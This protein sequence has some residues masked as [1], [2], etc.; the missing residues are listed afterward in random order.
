MAADLYR[1]RMLPLPTL[2][3]GCTTDIQVVVDHTRWPFP[4]PPLDPTKALQGFSFGLTLPVPLQFVSSTY[5]GTHLQQQLAGDP[6]FSGVRAVPGS[7][8]VGV[9]CDDTLDK[10]LSE[11]T[12]QIVIKIRV[13][14][15]PGTP[16]QTLSLNFVAGLGSPPVPLT[17][18]MPQLAVVPAVQGRTLTVGS[19]TCLAPTLGGF[20]P[21]LVALP[22]QSAEG[23][24]AAAGE[25]PAADP[26]DEETWGDEE[27]P[28]DPS[29]LEFPEPTEDEL[30]VVEVED[31]ELLEVAVTAEA[32]P[33]LAAAEPEAGASA[34]L[35]PKTDGSAGGAVAL[36]AAGAAGAAPCDCSQR[37]DPVSR[38]IEVCRETDGGDPILDGENTFVIDVPDSEDVVIDVLTVLVDLSFPLTASDIMTISLTHPGGTTVDLVG[39]GTLAPQDVHAFF[40]DEGL[41]FSGSSAEAVCA[42]KLQS[43]GLLSDLAGLMTAGEWELGIDVTGVGTATGLLN[44]CCILANTPAYAPI[45]VGEDACDDP[46]AALVEGG[47]GNTFSI[48]TAD[49]VEIFDLK[50]SVEITHPDITDLAISIESPAGTTVTLRSAGAPMAT[51]I[52]LDAIWADSGLDQADVPST[53][54]CRILPAAG[55]LSDFDGEMS[56]PEGGSWEL[57]ITDVANGM[58]GT[59]L[60][61]CVLVNTPDITRTVDPALADPDDPYHP[62]YATIEEAV[63]DAEEGRVNHE[64]IR[65]TGGT[66]D[67]LVVVNADLL[68]RRTLWLYADS[69]PDPAAPAGSPA[70]TINGGAALDVRCMAITG[71]GGEECKITIGGLRALSPAGSDPDYDGWRGFLLVEGGATIFE[72]GAGILVGEELAGPPG[73]QSQVNLVGNVI[74]GNGADPLDAAI[75][76]G[77]VAVFRSRDVFIFQN[78]VTGNRARINGAGL[79]LEDSSTVLVSNWIDNNIFQ[80]DDPPVA[81]RQ[82]GG[83]DFRGG[84]AVMCAN[85]IRDN[86]ARQG[87]GVYAFLEQSTIGLTDEP[88]FHFERN[89]VYLNIA[90]DNSM[91]GVAG[92]CA[93]D[94]PGYAGGGLYVGGS[95]DDTIPDDLSVAI[96]SNDI[97]LNNI[98]IADDPGNPDDGDPCEDENDI[99]SQAGGGVFLSLSM[100]DGSD[101]RPPRYMLNNF[102][103]QNTARARAGGIWL[104]AFASETELFPFYHNTVVDN[105]LIED[106]A[107][108]ELGEELYLPFV[109]AYPQIDGKNSIVYH[110]AGNALPDWYAECDPDDVLPAPAAWGNSQL[111]AEVGD[112]TPCDAGEVNFSIFGAGASALDPEIVASSNPHL[113]NRD[114][115]CF[116]TGTDGL[117]DFGFIPLALDIDNEPRPEFRPGDLTSGEWD[118]GADELTLGPVQFRRGDCDGSGSVSALLDALF[119][120]EYQFIDGDEPPCLA[121]ANADDSPT[122]VALLDALYLL[123]WQFK[124]GPVPPAPG[125]TA[126][127]VDPTP[128]EFVGC[129]DDTACVP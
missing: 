17:F 11:G 110:V 9:L 54:Q 2:Y 53:C 16:P 72:S 44:E 25:V 70:A 107:Y 56:A 30:I 1:L 22:L 97:H 42:C 84:N 57:F 75:E 104:G 33:E 31:F 102:V 103:H 40:A 64:A 21:A 82:G 79:H 19:G 113:R 78:Q 58:T 86:E 123:S 37:V 60:E 88:K 89:D 3:P 62:V 41:V 80:D 35:E 105:V 96:V 111:R 24:P 55:S 48:T 66:Y 68:T 34:P 117:D 49:D 120:L 10:A 59:L 52:D 5:A 94:S 46:A 100:N 128:N 95:T 115:P 61:W 129:E 26:A 108:E 122:V 106:I 99:P 87:C 98:T 20:A 65:V 50:L 32:A 126:C 63:D 71:N 125:P 91:Q 124:G 36:G 118:R 45:F 114:S 4:G 121:A 18:A 13:T 43:A 77:G 92:T 74:D 12:S 81:S 38:G 29:E 127:G 90:W 93:V 27:P 85:T 112:P 67:E 73:F 14:V 15:P 23:E 39:I 28:P 47:A 109:A 69:S 76:G 8:T 119:L 6:W 51:E 101:P 116:D 7:V 83:V